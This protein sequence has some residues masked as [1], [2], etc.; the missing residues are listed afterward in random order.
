MPPTTTDSAV[1][2]DLLAR[3]RAGDRAA[4]DAL[5]AEHRPYLRRLVELR[6]DPQLQPRADPSDVVQDALLAAAE[7]IDGYL[8]RD[9]MPFWLWLRQ[10][11]CDRLV[12][13]QRRHLGAARRATGR[14]LPL[15]SAS[16]IRLARSLLG[17]DTP[18]EKVVRA[19][20]AERVRAAVARLDEDDRTIILL[21]NFEELSNHQA[22]AVLGIEPAA[23][24]KRLG[25]AL[26]RLKTVLDAPSPGDRP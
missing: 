10:T 3:L 4:L 22:A 1:T 16:S 24:S 7:R 5:L 20:L 11:A 18:S 23:A 12:E 9:P 8:R 2:C 19:E 14:E 26:L 25:R 6:F 13:L 17:G 15:P 21:R